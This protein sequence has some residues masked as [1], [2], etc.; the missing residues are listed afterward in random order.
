MA[1]VSTLMTAVRRKM[2]VR[3][4]MGEFDESTPFDALSND[5]LIC[6]PEAFARAERAAEESVALLKVDRALLPLHRV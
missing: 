1:A 6:T 5:T 4:R 3:L 2:A